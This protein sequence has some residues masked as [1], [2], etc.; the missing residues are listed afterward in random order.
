VLKFS[1]YLIDNKVLHY[2]NK[3]VNFFKKIFSEYCDAHRELRVECVC[4]QTVNVTV[5]ITYSYYWVSKLDMFYR[6]LYIPIWDEEGRREVTTGFT[7]ILYLA[8][9]K[10]QNIGNEVLRKVFGSEIQGVGKNTRIQRERCNLFS[11]PGTVN[12]LA[13]ELFF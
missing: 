6:T 10:I 2:Y 12:L 8:T 1:P 11:L 9:E 5:G 13:L 3:S 7:D 4:G